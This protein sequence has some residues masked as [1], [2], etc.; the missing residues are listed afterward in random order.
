MQS[1]I[2]APRSE[3]GTGL[4]GSAKP[5]SCRHSQECAASRA[6]CESGNPETSTA[7]AARDRETRGS[8]EAEKRKRNVL[9]LLMLRRRTDIPFGMFGRKRMGRGT[10]RLDGSSGGECQLSATDA[11]LV[12]GSCEQDLLTEPENGV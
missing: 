6:R 10:I 4:E 12:D 1:W 5:F 9:W 2:P 8:G 11:D 7:Q 3:S